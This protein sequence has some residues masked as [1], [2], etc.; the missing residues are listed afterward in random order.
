MES[1]PTEKAVVALTGN[2]YVTL[3]SAPPAGVAYRVKN[4]YGQNNAGA[5]RT[6]TLAFNEGGTRTVVWQSA[7]TADAAMFTQ[8]GGGTQNFNLDLSLTNT[9]ESLDMQLEAAGTDRVVC[10]Y[11]VA[12]T[13]VK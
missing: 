4:V 10:I 1:F 11:E 6:L 13:S 7:S 2:T 12:E 9:D 5:A 8:T 3:V